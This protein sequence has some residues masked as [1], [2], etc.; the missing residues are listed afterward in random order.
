M[1]EIMYCNDFTEKYQ[2]ADEEKQKKL[3]FYL[4]TSELN[5]N[6]FNKEIDFD[7]HIKSL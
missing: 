6:Y 4:Y 2:K 3:D 1:N 7:K 5:K